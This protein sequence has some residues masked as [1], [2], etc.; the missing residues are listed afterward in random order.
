MLVN[1]ETKNQNHRITYDLEY[2]PR[3]NGP[4]WEGFS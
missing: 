4:N 2:S 3:G 1:Y